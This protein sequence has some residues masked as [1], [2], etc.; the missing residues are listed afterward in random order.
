MEWYRS[1]LKVKHHIFTL[2]LYLH[3]RFLATSY[4]FF[5]SLPPDPRPSTITTTTMSSTST[6]PS[7]RLHLRPLLSR[8][9]SRLRLRRRHPVLYNPEPSTE[10]LTS[11]TSD[12][13]SAIHNDPDT[14]LM[15]ILHHPPENLRGTM[16]M[17]TVHE[18]PLWLTRYLLDHGA[19]ESTRLL[20]D[21]R[22][23]LEVEDL[24][25]PFSMEGS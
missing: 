22:R 1:R 17:A 13:A 23:I 14:L 7:R 5:V 4:A 21:R 20:W 10:T 9:W 3:D 25:V 2:H 24:A 12:P 16:F 11:T 8:L 6:K 18:L 15:A 19:A